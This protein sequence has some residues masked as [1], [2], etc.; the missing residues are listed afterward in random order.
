M[1]AQRRSPV[2]V[3]RQY[4]QLTDVTRQEKLVDQFRQVAVACTK[5]L[6]IEATRNLERIQ[7]ERVETVL[8]PHGG[9]L[10][11]PFDAL[12]YQYSV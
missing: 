4:V 3:P 6:N 2:P 12:V 9:D 5:T 7:V 11:F 10:P 8:Q 1:V